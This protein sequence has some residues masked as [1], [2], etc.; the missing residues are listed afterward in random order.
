MRRMTSTI[1]IAGLGLALLFAGTGVA[2]AQE[3]PAPPINAEV[4]QQACENAG[5]TLN[6]AAF[7]FFCSGT[8]TTTNPDVS[9]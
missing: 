7:P 2:S 8:F 5:G 6:T 3:G 1:G 9:G 4:T